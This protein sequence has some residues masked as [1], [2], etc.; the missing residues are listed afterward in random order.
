M[1]L[2]GVSMPVV[3]ATV[4]AVAGCGQTLDVGRDRSHTELPVDERNPLI[5]INDGWS[6]NWSG[7]YAM[8]LANSGGPPLV[9]LVVGTSLYW[10]DLAGNVAGWNDMATAGRSSGLKDVPDVT[11]GSAT[12]LEPPADGRIEST[13]PI[14]SA[15]AKLIVDLSLQL[16][17]PWRPVVLA[18]CTQLTDIADAYLMDPTVADRVVVVALLGHSQDQK[19]LM[20]GPNGD[21]DPWA[22]WIVAQ[23]FRYV[24]ISATYNDQT[25]Y[26]VTEDDVVD[27]PNNAF[28]DWM[29]AKRPNV[30][31]LTNAADQIAVLAVALRNFAGTAQRASSDTSAGFNSP[32]GQGPPLVPDANGN[33][34]LVTDIDVDLPR[35]RLWEMLLDPRTWGS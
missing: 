21:L 4:L 30:M 29:A 24:Q 5:M 16:S 23:R 6:D 9:G 28:G 27:L 34:W 13:V 32:P 33:A 8:L 35:P 15:G 3:L 22:D 11:D 10:P 18:A 25:T 12:Q 19:G 14:G 26:D 31:R 17:L 7:E 20:T 2:A 1:I